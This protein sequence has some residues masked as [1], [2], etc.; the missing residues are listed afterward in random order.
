MVT[1]KGKVT[2]TDILRPTKGDAETLKKKYNFHPIILDEILHPS[3]RS[4]VEKY[5][6]YLFLTYHLPFYDP[7]LKTARRAEIDFL[8]TK[9][10]VKYVA[11]PI[12][13]KRNILILYINGCFII[14]YI[15][16]E[17]TAE[18]KKVKKTFRTGKRIK[19]NFLV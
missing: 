2:W 17:A 16:T 9:K 3:A 15:E 6:N 7:I 19:V 1:V 4:R 13:T 8:I 11:V 12:G 18:V 10:I 5:N 14:K